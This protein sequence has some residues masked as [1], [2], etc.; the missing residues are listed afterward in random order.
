MTA[1]D[2]VHIC[3]SLITVTSNFKG[4]TTK[5]INQ[6]QTAK[7]NYMADNIQ[8]YQLDWGQNGGGQTL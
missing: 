2:E 6:K 5:C 3:L 1:W 4:K 7:A 8:H